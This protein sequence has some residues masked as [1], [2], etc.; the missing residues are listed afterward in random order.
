MIKYGSID[1]WNG[2][3]NIE[4]KCKEKILQYYLKESQGQEI[5]EIWYYRTLVKL[6]ELLN[7]TKNKNLVK[8]A[9]IILLYFF[10]NIPIDNFST[11]GVGLKS[12]SN[13]EKN[14]LISIL[15]KELK[16]N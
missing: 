2:I 9:L 3:D 1:C 8:N 5:S 4:A 10:K 15:K 6:M 7:R 13:K 16:A 11:Q 12:L 14:A